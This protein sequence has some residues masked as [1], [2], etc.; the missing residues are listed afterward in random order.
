MT[1]RQ[2]AAVALAFTIAAALAVLLTVPLAVPLAAQSPKGWMVRP[3]R[4]ASASDPDVAGD[5]KFTTSGSGFHAVNPQAAAYWNPANTIAGTYTLKGTFTLNTPSNHT[6]YY[7]LI[8]GGSGLD[9][10]TCGADSN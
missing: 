9:G 8:L 10:Y 7:G 5:I 3:D 6:N 2:I 1:I 4:S